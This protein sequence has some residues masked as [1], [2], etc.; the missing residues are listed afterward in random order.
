MLDAFSCNSPPAWTRTKDHRGIS[1]ALYQLSYR[2]TKNF[3]MNIHTVLH[4]SSGALLGQ[5]RKN[6]KIYFY[7]IFECSSR[8][9][10]LPTELQADMRSKAQKFTFVFCPNIQSAR[11]LLQAGWCQNYSAN[12]LLKQ[13]VLHGLRLLSE[14]CRNGKRYS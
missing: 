10:F 2:R 3:L 4:L 13:T 14:G 8:K 12:E 6:I 5:M 9:I 11:F 7:I 1:S